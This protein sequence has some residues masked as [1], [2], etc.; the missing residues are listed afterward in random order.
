MRAA[1]SFTLLALLTLLAGCG[2]ETLDEASCP[3]GGTTLTYEN[4]GRSFFAAHCNRCHSAPVGDRE[5]APE[6]YVFSTHA[7]VRAQADRIFARSA[8]DNVSMP[9]GPDDPPLEARQSL[10]VWL[11]CGAP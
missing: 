11:A 4:F 1:L 2:F 9:P 5:G 3:P 8:G 10:A 6:G 7:E